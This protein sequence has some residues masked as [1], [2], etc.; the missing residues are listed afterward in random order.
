MPR[1]IVDYNCKLDL[2]PMHKREMAYRTGLSSRLKTL[3][4]MYGEH[5]IFLYL[6]MGA[7]K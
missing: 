1:D 5:W 7:L 6:L 3:K 2:E 4:A